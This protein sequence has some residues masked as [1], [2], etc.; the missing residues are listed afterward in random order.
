MDG[1]SILEYDQASEVYE[2]VHQD[3]RHYCLEMILTFHQ[4]SPDMVVFLDISTFNVENK[5]NKLL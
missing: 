4:L 5:C 3:I 2:N 1:Y